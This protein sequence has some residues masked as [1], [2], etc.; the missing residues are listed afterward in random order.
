VATVL[1]VR[2]GITTPVKLAAKRPYII[3][4]AFVVGM[5]MTPPD[6]FSQV[7]L[8]VPVWLL[9]EAGL[10][11]SRSIKPRTKPEP[12]DEDPEDEAMERELE[13]GIAEFER[14]DS[15]DTPPRS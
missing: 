1:L 5:L 4:G 13:E 6:M 12:Q 3:V 7:M 8:A 11:F 10:Y 9:F 2:M 15:Q 14:L